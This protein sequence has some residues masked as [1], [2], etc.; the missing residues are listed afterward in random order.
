[1]V[2]LS[3]Q[4]FSEGGLWAKKVKDVGGF[5]EKRLKDKVEGAFTSTSWHSVTESQAPEPES[6]A[7]SVSTDVLPVN[8]ED[9]AAVI[10]IEDASPSLISISEEELE[11]TINRARL[12]GENAA[13]QR[14]EESFESKIQTAKDGQKAFFEAL[15]HNLNFSSEFTS[16]LSQLALA[17]GEMIARSELTS[18]REVI[19][20]FLTTVINQV[21]EE[22]QVSATFLIADEWRDLIKTLDM[23]SRYPNYK[24]EF[25]RTLKPGSV[26]VMYGNGGFEDNIDQRIAE[27]A[28]QLL[29]YA[30]LN[31]HLSNLSSP[32]N[33]HSSPGSSSGSDTE[34]VLPN[35]SSEMSDNEI[36]PHE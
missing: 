34:L 11:A 21:A 3:N 18:N 32:N 28:Q 15:E 19:D 20:R 14:L 23:E 35:D 31:N 10:P 16:Q 27:L 22:G 26:S 8:P 30:P 7:E 6:V 17:L 2:I 13:K 33:P 4:E 12:E 24:F 25:D 1:V 36:D 29:N 9:D 5:V